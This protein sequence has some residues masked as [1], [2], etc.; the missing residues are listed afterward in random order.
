MAETSVRGERG[1][2]RN[3]ENMYKKVAS[4]YG[5]RS[6]EEPA[7]RAVFPAS[8]REF[9]LCAPNSWGGKNGKGRGRTVELQVKLSDGTD[10]FGNRVNFAVFVKAANLGKDIIKAVKREGADHGAPIYYCCVVEACEDII[11]AANEYAEENKIPVCARGVTGNDRGNRAIRRR[12][13][14][15]LIRL[16]RFVGTDP[17]MEYDQLT[18][19][20]FKASSYSWYDDATANLDHEDR[21]LWDHVACVVKK[22]GMKSLASYF[23]SS[24]GAAAP[25]GPAP[26]KAKK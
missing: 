14:I 7:T 25:G 8:T 10:P 20:K 22:K 3:V 24:K 23:G 5:P 1:D 21:P 13:L 2:P 16:R 26:K 12:R 9:K 4:N 15:Q 19:D 17:K 18:P 6:G 11:K